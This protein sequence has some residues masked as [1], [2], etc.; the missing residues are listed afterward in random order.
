MI[1]YSI[2]ISLLL[3]ANVFFRPTEIL[4]LSGI[5]QGTITQEEEYNTITFEIELHLSDKNGKI[6]GTSIINGLDIGARI[7]LEGVCDAGISLTLKDIVI[8]ESTVIEGEEMEWCLKSYILTVKR[9]KDQIT[10][11]GHWNGTT[12]FDICT[13]GKVFLKRGVDRA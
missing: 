1:I 9:D 3:Q 10:L 6:T 7:D 2:V 12:S 13:P 11:E 8:K 5:W 4:D